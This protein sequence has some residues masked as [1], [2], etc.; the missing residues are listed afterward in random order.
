M[1]EIK[2]P[3]DRKFIK[4]PQT[5]KTVRQNILLAVG[6]V[7]VLAGIFLCI[8]VYTVADKIFVLR[9]VVLFV[10]GTVCLYMSLAFTRNSVSLFFG[11]AFILSGLVTLCTDTKIIPYTMK[12]FWPL[13]V[14]S[15]GIALFP[16]GFYKMKRIR[17]VYFFPAVT[18]VVLGGFFLLF[19]LHVIRISFARFFLLSWPFILIVCG[20]SLV[21]I[22]L[23][24]QTHHKQF[25]YLQDDSLV[26]SDDDDN[27]PA[28]VEKDAP[29]Q[30]TG[31]TDALK[32]GGTSN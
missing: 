25:P 13:I 17:T 19:S 23:W 16:A 9:P 32:S 1:N 30:T 4:V 21:V 18:L 26:E 22:F 2:P 20:L 29:V 28:S 15:S 31:G 10:M 6:M 8:K 7:L 5:K 3:K 27:K 11:L 14:I 12:E 24:Q